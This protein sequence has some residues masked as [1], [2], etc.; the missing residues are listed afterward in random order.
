[1]HGR[2]KAFEASSQRH[3]ANFNVRP[4]SRDEMRAEEALVVF[5]RAFWPIDGG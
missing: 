2:A 3:S 1:M 5:T 4:R